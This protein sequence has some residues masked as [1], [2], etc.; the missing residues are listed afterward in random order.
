[1]LYDQHNRRVEKEVDYSDLENELEN[2]H[3]MNKIK[4]L[5]QVMT[6]PDYV[7]R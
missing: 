6:D 7:A 4:I 5:K 2:G 1:M 3:D